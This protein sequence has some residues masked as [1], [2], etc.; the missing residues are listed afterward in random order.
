MLPD[1]IADA[2]S[3]V[4]WKGGRR[5]STRPLVVVGHERGRGRRRMTGGKKRA[6]TMTL[7]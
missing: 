7:E 3:M 6:G 1:D 2:R 5:W 4:R